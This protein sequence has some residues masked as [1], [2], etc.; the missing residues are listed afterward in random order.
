MKFEFIDAQKA[1]F[2]VDFMCQQLGVSRS[3]YYAWKDRPEAERHKKDSVLAEVVTQVQVHS[4]RPGHRRSGD[5]GLPG[6]LGCSPENDEHDGEDPAVISKNFSA[7]WEAR[8]QAEREGYRILLAQDPFEDW[9]RSRKPEWAA[10]EQLFMALEILYARKN[11]PEARSFLQKGQQIAERILAERKLESEVCRG[12]F[13]LNLARLLRTQAYISALLAEKV[14]F[15]AGLLRRAA[16]MNEEWCRAYSGRQWDSQVQAYYLAA[17][18]LC[19]IAGD[20]GRARE[21]LTTKKSFKWH[22]EEHRLWKQWVDGPRTRKDGWVE[23]DAYFDRLRDPNL[24]TDIFL[25]KGVLRL[26]LGVLRHR[27][28]EGDES[29]G[30][31]RVF[32]M[33]VA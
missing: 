13:P 10:E 5:H 23:F 29:G 22:E 7:T 9:E 24:K 8:Y 27:F 2:P 15:D 6:D 12:G 33:I 25:E 16:D 11:V 17:V 18:R 1:H 28:L 26:E 30:W 19:L 3:R 14:S 31:P 4:H 32:D 20:L 21:L